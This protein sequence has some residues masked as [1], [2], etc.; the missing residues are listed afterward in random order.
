MACQNKPEREAN[1]GAFAKEKAEASEPLQRIVA[2]GELLVATLSGPDTYFEYQGRGLGLQYALAEDFAETQGVGVRV[3]LCRDTLQMVAKLKAGEV[4]V[5]ALQLP[6]A[7]CRKYGIAPAGAKNEKKATSWAVLPEQPNLKTALDEWYGDGVELAAERKDK[8]WRSERTVVRRKV[9]AP[10]ISREKGIISTY[11]AL[12]K[13]AAHYTGWDWRLVAAQCYQESGFDPNAVSWAGAKGLMQ[14]MP[15]TA[16]HLGLS[17]DRVFSPTD[18]VTAAARYVRQ[19]Q[20]RFHDIPAAERYKFVLASYNGGQGHVQ[21]ARALARKYGRN[22]NKWE[23][24]GFYI[25][26]LSQP[27]FYR[28]PVVRYG[29]MIGEETYNYVESIVSR[30]RL[31]G[32]D[33]GSPSM[34]ATPRQEPG[35]RS[36]KGNGQSGNAWVLSPEELRKQ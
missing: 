7:L 10:Y 36:R 16:T 18:N 27:R 28:D 24:V 2:S 30:W 22:P 19:L 33:T 29:Y 34:A 3:D 21:D 35:E 23:E 6:L 31:Y 12:F 5:I 9:R 17:A 1:N 8:T 26:H 25:R 14:I 32:G 13:Q 4:D 15:A 11:D 20:G